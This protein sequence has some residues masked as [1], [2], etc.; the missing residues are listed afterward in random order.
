MIGNVI[1][2]IFLVPLIAWAAFYLITK[3]EVGVC[4]GSHFIEGETIMA[5][6]QKSPQPN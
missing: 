6:D 5:V 2:G 1:L 4:V 3:V